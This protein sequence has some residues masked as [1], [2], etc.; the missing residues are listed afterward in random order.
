MELP[1]RF[2]PLIRP[3]PLLLL[4]LA[5]PVLSGATTD[6]VW[7]QVTYST[8]PTIDERPFA[9]M[10]YD[11]VRGRAIVFGGTCGSGYYYNE[12]WTFVPGGP[13]NV[14]W[15]V[16]PAAGEPP[17]ARAYHTATYDPVRDRMIVFGG[18][19]G[20]TF[21]NDLWE[22][23]L[24]GTPTW[25]QMT[26]AGTP[27]CVRGTHAAIYDPVRDRVIVFGGRT[28]SNAWLNEVWVLSLEDTPT[29]TQ[30]A[31]AGTPP[32]VRQG[33]TAVYDEAGD[34]M[35]L[36]GGLNGTE[37]FADVWA[38]S[39]GDTPAWTNLT[40]TGTSPAARY[41][42][43]AIYDPVRDRM[44]VSAGTNGS[45]S[46]ADVWALSLSGTPAWT[47]LTPT[48]S[49][50]GA[51][52]GVCALYDPILDRMV[53]FG[54]YLSGFCLNDVWALSLGDAP[55][56]IMLS[57][58]G[59]PPAARDE[60]AAIHDPVRDRMLVF[61]G[62]TL[63]RDG[64]PCSNDVWELSL[65]G[66]PAWTQ[67]VPAGTR[68]SRRWSVAAIHDQARDRMVIFGGREWGDVFRNDTWVLSLGDRK[69]VV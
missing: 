18:Y 58:P 27:P 13:S 30:M 8:G 6:G 9:S 55:A 43:A 63:G 68:P 19:N 24:A 3:L 57:V 64:W 7:S 49:N 60:L 23:S 22:L 59:T 40:P 15:A 53:T 34:R 56:W 52:Y 10:V 31:P 20:T 2:R 67:L 39:L 36:F 4:G 33:M 62:Y 45:T 38:L 50:P 47:D 61:G 5:A 25:T 69:S 29:W 17:A 46:F 44:V 12:A 51:V 37:S 26:P 66:T 41:Y 14:E 21:L 16:L 35:L 28:N 32:S 1:R 48:D 65:P 54:G 11:P 42:H